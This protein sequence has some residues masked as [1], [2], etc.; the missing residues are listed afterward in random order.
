MRL[1]ATLL[2]LGALILA[3]LA[4]ARAYTL[5]YPSASAATQIHWPATNIT[6]ALSASLNN[7]PS[8]VHATGA[9]VVLA[10]RRALSRWALASNIQFTVT[11]SSNLTAGQDG[12]SLITIAPENANQFSSTLQ[13]GRAFVFFDPNTGLISEADLAINPKVTTGPG[14]ASFFS[15][16]G[17]PGRYDPQETFTHQSGHRLLYRRHSAQLPPRIYLHARDRPHARPRTLRPCFGDDAA[18]ARHERHFQPAE[19]YDAH[20]FPRR[21]GRHPLHLRPAHGVGQPRRSRYL[22]QRGT[23]RRACLRRGCGDGARLCGK[24]NPFDRQLPHRQPA[25]RTVSRRRRAARRAGQRARDTFVRRCLQR[26]PGRH[27][28][29]PDDR[30]RDDDRQRRRHH[31]VARHLRAGPHAQLQPG[32][33]RHGKQRP[34]LDRRRPRRAGANDDRARRRR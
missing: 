5:Q 34:A 30:G 22:R 11:A 21:R 3:P 15:A 24:R 10:A 28:A 12:V 33:H 27:H 29:F 17:P 9:Q 7:P 4:P 23:L 18:A 20:S 13:P 19:L 14:A 6:I 31:D 1:T 16:D 2:I 26:S 32:L 8:Y 25:A